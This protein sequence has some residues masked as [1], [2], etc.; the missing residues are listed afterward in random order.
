MFKELLDDDLGKNNHFVSSDNSNYLDFFGGYNKFMKVAE[1]YKEHLYIAGGYSYATFF[2]KPYDSFSDIDV[3]FT[4]KKLYDKF[5]KELKQSYGYQS[6]YE[7]K[8]AITLRQQHLKPLQIIKGFEEGLHYKDFDF[9]NS[10]FVMKYP[11]ETPE[12]KGSLDGLDVIELK[13]YIRISAGYKIN[14]IFDIKRIFKYVNDKGLS[15]HPKDYDN[16]LNF[17]TKQFTEENFIP[18]LYEKEYNEINL[19]KEEMLEK[20]YH[21]FVDLLIYS[22]THKNFLEKILKY[23]EKF[24]F[25]FIQ[26]FI[27]KDTKSTYPFLYSGIP[28]LNE[29]AQSVYPECF[30]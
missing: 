28:G 3:Y 16:I 11:F 13:E 7:S 22:K 25:E 2:N 8:V 6:S 24:N 20:V 19:T 21:L 27:E 12:Y 30:I 4:N 1:K 15:I 26:Y 5:I 9:E 29:K 17:Y 23:F 18:K 10:K 14:T